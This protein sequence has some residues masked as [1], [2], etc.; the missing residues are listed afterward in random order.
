VKRLQNEYD[1]LKEELNST[2]VRFDFKWLAKKQE[3]SYLKKQIMAARE[4]AHNDI[5]E[6]IN[7]VGSMGISFYDQ[8]T[9][10]DLHGLSVEAAKR[11]IDDPILH[12]LPVLKKIM[13]IT[14]RG[15]HSANG[16]CVLKVAIKSYLNELKVEC[17]E[18]KGNEGAICVH[19][20]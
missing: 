4:N 3:M 20:Q 17:E 11:F 12:V 18:V 15:L 10:I 19:M 9:T 5:Y 1:L 7:S 8:S 14:G 6:R 13:V 16:E 2:T